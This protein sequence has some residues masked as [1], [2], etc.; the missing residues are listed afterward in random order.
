MP[1]RI[2]CLLMCMASIALAIAMAPTAF[3]MADRAP[4]I[5]EMAIIEMILTLF[6]IAYRALVT[7]LT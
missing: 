3:E 7:A 2:L 5:L 6:Y 1:K 4:W